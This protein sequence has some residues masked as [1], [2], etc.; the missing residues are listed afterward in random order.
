MS[1][2]RTRGEYAEASIDAYQR[3]V[4]RGV[5]PLVA[6]QK[7]VNTMSASV[8]ASHRQEARHLADH[9]IKTY[10]RELTS[11]S[12]VDARSAAVQQVAPSRSQS[13]E[14]SPGIDVR[15][16]ARN[17]IESAAKTSNQDRSIYAHA[18]AAA[19]TGRTTLRDAATMG[20]QAVAKYNDL[21]QRGADH[22][23]ARDQVA[24]QIAARYDERGRDTQRQ[25]RQQSQGQSR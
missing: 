6:H 24:S 18:A 13:A 2:R 23:Q 11:R 21:R 14:R 5:S 15:S 22:T 9:A 8:S 4:S 1:E 16:Y 3:E 7:A 20:L 10:A 17:V 12:P 19:D 25:V